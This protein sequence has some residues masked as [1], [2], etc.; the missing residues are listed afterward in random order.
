[1]K[2]GNPAFLPWV[3]GTVLCIYVEIFTLHGEE[4][5]SDLAAILTN[6]CK[7]KITTSRCL[8]QFLINE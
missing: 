4:I 7:I 1:M 5:Y 3:I 6:A 8:L 2:K